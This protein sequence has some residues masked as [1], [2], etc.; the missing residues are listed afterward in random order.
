MR[1]HRNVA[2]EWSA[3][4]LHC[5]CCP[6]VLHKLMPNLRLV[7]TLRD[8][9]DRALSRFEE[10][11]NAIHDIADTDGSFDD[12]VSRHLPALQECLETAT[13][14]LA[15]TTCLAE[16]NILG[17][18]IYAIPIKNYLQHF[19][20]GQMLVTYLDRLEEQPAKF[21]EQIESHLHLTRHGYEHIESHYNAEGDY[22]WDKAALLAS[23]ETVRKVEDDLEDV[24]PIS[25]DT[26][27]KLFDFY[28]PHVKQ[29]KELGDRGMSESMPSK[30]IRTWKLSSKQEHLVSYGGNVHAVNWVRDSNHNK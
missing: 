22:G 15:K 8:P 18:S 27:D 7:A 24:H 17:P 5:G 3:T 26:R 20:Q 28:R 4:Y 2:G 19:P 12:Y 30:W 29:L 10:Q 6:E 11:H 9:I 14:L 13:T 25:K 16:D 23:G 21:M 1:D